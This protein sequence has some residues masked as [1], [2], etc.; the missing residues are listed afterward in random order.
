MNLWDEILA[1]VETKVNRHSFYTW[2]KP[3]TFI[4]ADTESVTVRVPNPLFKDWLMKHYAGVISEAMREVK[5]PN[6]TVNFVAE[7]QTRGRAAR[8]QP[9]RS[10]RPSKASRCRRRLGRPASTPATRSTH[11]SSA[12]R[13]SSRTRRVARSPK[14][15]RA[16]TTR[17]SSTAAWDSAR[18]T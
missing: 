8:A 18:R 14:R 13:I 11:S 2:F 4:A 15:R 6:L 12:H 17:C 9:R 1:R 3:T 7:P 16:R 10:A 5:Q